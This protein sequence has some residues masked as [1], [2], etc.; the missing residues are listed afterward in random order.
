MIRLLQSPHGLAPCWILGDLLI[1]TNMIGIVKYVHLRDT[2]LGHVCQALC[3]V[4]DGSPKAG[5]TFP[6]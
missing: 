1:P 4:I 5:Y 6:E 2:V 3:G